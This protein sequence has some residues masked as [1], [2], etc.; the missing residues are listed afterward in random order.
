MGNNAS[1]SSSPTQKWQAKDKNVFITGA[2]A[3]IG[4]QIATKFAAQGASLALVARSKDRLNEVAEE[5]RKLGAP[6]VEVFPCDLTNSEN[7]KSATEQATAS[8]KSFD[9]A[10]LNAGRSQGCYFEEIKDVSQMD[11]LLRLNVNGVLTTLHYLLKSIPKSGDS[12]I[13][14]IS[15]IAGRVGI[16][17]RTL[18]C[19]SKH[20]LTGFANALRMELLDTYGADN[21]PAV[22]LVNFPEVS[23]T[24]LNTN[25]MTMGAD[26]PPAEFDGSAAVD[27]ATACDD[28]MSNIAAGT[29]ESGLSSTKTKLL[30]PLSG[31]IPT[32][33]DSIIMKHIKATHSRPDDKKEEEAANVGDEEL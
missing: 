19:A 9:V 23:G 4:K 32:T 14:V 21:A 5:C 26:R 31:V 10:F 28:L 11:Y 8:F 27:V 13:V 18:Y 3:G 16:P 6:V 2:S 30:V 1:S 29:R 12:R 22:C 33:T 15:S 24:D 7:I 25:R 17:Y 20:A